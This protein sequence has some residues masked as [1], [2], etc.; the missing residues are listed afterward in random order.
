MNSRVIKAAI[1][2]TGFMAKTHLEA[3][4]LVKGGNATVIVSRTYEKA[5][6]LASKYGIEASENLEKTLKKQDIDIVDICVPTY[7]HRE[8]VELAAENGKHILLEK[9]IATTLEDAD[10][11]VSVSNKFNV[12]L[13][14]A[15]VLRYFSEYI[16]IRKKVL[17]GMI[18]YPKHI[19]A[20]RKSTFPSWA[21]WFKDSEKSG[22][23]IVDLAIHDI[24]FLRWCLKDEVESVYCK[25]VKIRS[26]HEINDH[27]LIILRFNKGCIA[28]VEAAWSLPKKAPFIMNIE[29]YGTKGMI[30]YSNQENSPITIITDLE[31]ETHSPDSLTYSPEILP[32]PI[33]PY[34]REIQDFVNCIIRD[35]EPPIPA[36]EA[37]KSLE[38]CLA[39]LKSS[40]D[41]KEVALK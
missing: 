28:H 21:E 4:Q 11:I 5:K 38:V 6:Q 1:I 10:K 40:K 2:G 3:W 13:M 34:Y 16:E 15:H 9:P 17:N 18:G 12:K 19:R 41:N 31:I 14:V 25:E 32:F 29:I 39:A 26:E 23:V 7:L 27:A 24:D 30:N 8:Y 20:S 22:G 33:D 36:Q 35:E 37:K